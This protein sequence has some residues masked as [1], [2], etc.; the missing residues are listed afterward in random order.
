MSKL[1]LGIL[2]TWRL[3]KLLKEE[4]GPYEILARL[5]QWV[6]VRYDVYSTAYSDNELGRAFLC[7]WCLSLWIALVL[8]RGKVMETLAYSGGAIL[9]EESLN[10]WQRS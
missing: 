6:G 10:A 5:R 3:T 9:I 7:F 4:R 8:G 1:L 2:A